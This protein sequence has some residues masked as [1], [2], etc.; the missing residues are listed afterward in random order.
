MRFSTKG[1]VLNYSSAECTATIQSGFSSRPIFTS[2]ETLPP[3]LTLHLFLRND[4]G[5]LQKIKI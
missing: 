2:F 5:E 4:G 1:L 3:R